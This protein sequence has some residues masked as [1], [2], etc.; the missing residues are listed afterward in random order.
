MD[1][2]SPHMSTS[3]FSCSPSSNVLYLESAIFCLCYSSCHP[4]CLLVLCGCW[5]VYYQPSPPG[6]CH[7][8]L[9]C[10]AL[11]LLFGDMILA[12]FQD[13]WTILSNLWPAVYPD[14][15]KMTFMLQLI[16]TQIG[17]WHQIWMENLSDLFNGQHIGVCISFMVLE[18]MHPPCEFFPSSPA[19][20]GKLPLISWMLTRTF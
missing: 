11:F 12:Y 3:Y 17:C 15:W 16:F 9:A 1:L 13:G 5:H 10:S 20:A 8:R 14:T 2:L 7:H 18:K 4:P 6:C 19:S